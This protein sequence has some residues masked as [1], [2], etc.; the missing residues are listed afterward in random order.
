VP[1]LI[2]NPSQAGPSKPGPD[3][4]GPAK[5]EMEVVD[6]RNNDE[7]RTR[8]MRLH[9]VAKAVAGMQRLTH[10]FAKSP[11]D[12]LQELVEVSVEMCGADSAGIT[13]EE[14][15][16]EG[17]TQFRW[18]ATAGKY[19]AFLGAVLPRAYSPCGTCLDRGGP[20]LF[21]VSKAYLDMIGVE[22]PPVTDGLLI[23]WQVDG[24]RG[25]IWVLAHGPWEL[26]DSEDY[27]LLQSL[28]DIA[29]IGVR[30]QRDRAEQLRQAAAE[31]TAALANDLAHQ[32]NNPLQSLVLT[33]FLAE[34]ES[35]DNK[36]LIHKAMEDLNRLTGLVKQ[37][38]NIHRGAAAAPPSEYP[39]TENRS[40]PRWST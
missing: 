3:E 36:L 6:L 32:I 30:H 16:G 18:I 40:G 9:E 21:R 26:F 15:T 2:D 7:F 17:E 25:T 28:A 20:Q 22:A 4:I 39:E 1:E 14:E 12:I 29:A 35:A 23:P 11:S 8:P 31:A 24:A 5:P 38:L 34:K 33:I 27:H 13:L 37:L 19:G 10:V